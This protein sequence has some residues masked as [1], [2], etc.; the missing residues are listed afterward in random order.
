MPRGV[1]K[2]NLPSKVCE[3][4]KRPF[5]WRKV[6]ERCWDEVKTCSDRCKAERK[7]KSRTKGED[8]ATEAT[9]PQSNLTCTTSELVVSKNPL[10]RISSST[11]S[12]MV[13]SSVVEVCGGGMNRMVN[14][15]WQM[16][17]LLL[18]SS[19]PYF[20]SPNHLQTA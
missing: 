8:D 10:D 15:A 7:K 13:M 2:E 17:L 4:C 12:K 6:W 11:T 19:Q 1:K 9:D 20:L 18:S 5:T 14:V 3:V 16:H